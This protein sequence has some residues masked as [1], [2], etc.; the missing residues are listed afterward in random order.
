MLRDELYE[1]ICELPIIDVHSHLNRDNM[2][3]GELRD[4]MFYHMLSYPLRAAGVP[5]E[6]LFPPGKGV[7]RKAAPFD[8]AMGH[9]QTIGDTS[10][11]WALKTILRELYDFDEPVTPESLPRLRAAFDER[12]AQPDW[13]E[14]VRKRANIRRILSSRT[15]VKPLAAG[16]SDKAIRFTLE[17]APTSGIREFHPWP[18][19]I[20]SLAK[21]AG[22]EITTLGALREVVAAYYDKYDFSDKR[23]LV[24]WVSSEAD[25]LPA[26]EPGIDA[27]L[28][29]ASAGR[30]VGRAGIRK[31][32]AVLLRCICE[33]IR[34]KTDVF[35]ICYGTQFL[36]PGPLHPVTRA[37]PQF[38]SGFAWLAGEFPEI[39]FNLLS[40]HEPDE[41]ALCSLCLA[42]AN[43][44][45]AGYWWNGFYPSVMHAAWAR[46]LDMVPTSRLCGF[47]SDGWC[48]D[49]TY[50]RV[51][52]TQRVLAN[53][54]AEK[55]DRGFY[56]PDQALR[57]ARTILF[58][59]PKQLFLPDEAVEE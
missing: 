50:A 34:G 36:T 14:Q 15:D 10:F 59:T 43:V 7:H 4:V 45:V 22:R 42:Y 2:A 13:D 5:E 41:P 23:A 52:M 54:L 27:L 12:T 58:D 38:A 47:F 44:S 26:G 17:T 55:V 20:R 21:S 39:H 49:W 48:I 8:E 32:E 29:D 46:R 31:L 1:A 16:D 40:G 37:F 3:A 19:R 24:A 57:V 28:A 56:T 30:E 9:W 18:E 33:A 51:R 6:L 11:G 25:F 35:Q 53:V